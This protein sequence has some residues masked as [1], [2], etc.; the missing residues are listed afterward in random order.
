[1]DSVLQMLK[2]YEILPRLNNQGRRPEQVYFSWMRG[3]VSSLFFTKA[4]AKVFAID[5]KDFAITGKDN[6]ANPANFARQPEADFE[7][8]LQD[9]VLRIEMQSGYQGVNDIKE[10]K[11]R[12]ARRQSREQG[13][14]TVVVHFDIF[15]GQVAFVNLSTITDDNIHWITRQQ[16]EGQTVFNIDQSCFIWNLRQTPPT[17]DSIKNL[18]FE[19]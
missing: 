2:G 1:M 3:W 8:K 19:Q 9:K 4:L 6:L 12:E 18:I 17:L 10:Y 15:N 16:M 11:V 13:I 5:E 7:I 14:C